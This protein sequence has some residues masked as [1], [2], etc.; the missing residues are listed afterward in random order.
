MASE[1]EPRLSLT[2]DCAFVV[3]FSS[4]SA[5][6]AGRMVGRVEHV[7][8]RQATTFHSLEALLAFL[9]HV[10]REGP[11]GSAET[12]PSPTGE[13]PLDPRRHGGQASRR[14]GSAP[15]DRHEGG[16]FAG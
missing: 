10:L 12:S 4:G 6:E 11:A 9:A 15:E 7:V 1:I 16:F 2:P 14:A 5:I 13:S 8:S 3:Q